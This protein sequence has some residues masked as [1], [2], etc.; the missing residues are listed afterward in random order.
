MGIIRILHDNI[1]KCLQWSSKQMEMS[2]FKMP[3]SDEPL[4]SLFCSRSQVGDVTAVH[5]AQLF[6]GLHSWKFRVHVFLRAPGNGYMRQITN[7]PIDLLFECVG[8]PFSQSV[9]LWI[10]ESEHLLYFKKA[11]TEEYVPFFFHLVSN[12]G[13]VIFIF[14]SI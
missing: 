5:P 1:D 9:N 14:I 7:A 3:L 8:D 10:S 2:S 12:T 13:T 11:P 4:S 6:M